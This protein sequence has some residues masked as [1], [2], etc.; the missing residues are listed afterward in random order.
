MDHLCYFC[1]VLLCFHACLFVG[2]LWS[3]DGEGADLLALACDV[4][5]RRCPFSIGI[6]GQVWCLIVLIPDL[7]P[8]SYFANNSTFVLEAE[9][10]KTLYQ[11]TRE[12][13]ILFISLPS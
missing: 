1:L 5:L 12:H 11:K 7:C 10:G 2:A 9:P 8:L 3:S 6:L 13:D 4:L